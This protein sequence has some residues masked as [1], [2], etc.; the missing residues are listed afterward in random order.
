MAW[1]VQDPAL[2]RNSRHSPH[3]HTPDS[4]STPYPLPFCRPRG[5]EGGG[6]CGTWERWREGSLL[7]PVLSVTLNLVLRD[8]QLLVG[9]TCPS[10]W[11]PLTIQHVALLS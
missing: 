9:K 5:S 6:S 7:L 11:I 10:G 3:P 1:E 8:E 2:G 4:T